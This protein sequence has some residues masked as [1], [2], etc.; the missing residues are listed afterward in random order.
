MGIIIVASM[1]AALSLTF[2]PLS[3][4][5]VLVTV[6]TAVLIPSLVLFAVDE[7]RD[8]LN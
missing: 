8:R 6:V 5:L 2:D 4:A 7:L 1:L 3:A